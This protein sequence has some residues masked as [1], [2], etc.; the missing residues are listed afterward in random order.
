MISSYEKATNSSVAS[1]NDILERIQA[2]LREAV[3]SLAPF[4][5][6]KVKAQ[7]KSF[8]R[9]PVT[10]AD[11]EVN[12]VLRKALVRDGEGW[13][14][15]ESVD[16]AKRLAMRRVWVVDP[17]DGTKEFV[18]GIPEWCVSVALV[19]G[20]RAIAGG[21]AN[22]ATHET[23]LGSRA[24]GLTYNGCPAQPTRKNS[25]DGAIVLASRSEVSR[26]EWA[27][28][29]EAPCTFR[30]MGSIAY[31]LALVAAGL[32]DATWTFQPKNEWDIAAGVALVQAAGGVVQFLPDEKPAF[33][34]EATLLPGLFA[35]G[36]KLRNPV[37]D[38]LRQFVNAS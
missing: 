30:P 13:L 9:G 4:V 22:P 29:A 23:F 37:K 31:K 32:A 6:G 8:G 3:E 21:I 2:A 27:K 15:E 18:A 26:G 36:P 24:T 20:G 14:S 38:F 1:T 19:E 28:F 35:C 7:Q 12:R 16:D 34:N 11:R 10:E 33:N 25:L 5:P 17:L